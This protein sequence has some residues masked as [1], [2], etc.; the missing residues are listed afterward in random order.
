MG[1]PKSHTHTHIKP[2]PPIQK[3]SWPKRNFVKNV[4]NPKTKQKYIAL[5]CCRSLTGDRDDTGWAP[6]CHT[7]CAKFLWAFKVKLHS[8]VAKVEEIKWN[9]LKYNQVN[10]LCFMVKC[11]GGTVVGWKP[12]IVYFFIENISKIPI[13]QI[14]WNFLSDLVQS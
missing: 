14:G 1:R 8:F 3:L 10:K 2:A 12:I 11:Q 4:E 7:M 13:S 5:F 6:L 9:Y